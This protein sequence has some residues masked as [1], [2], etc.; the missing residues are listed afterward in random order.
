MCK[1]C[2]ECGQV[3]TFFLVAQDMFEAMEY[4]VKQHV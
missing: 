1:Q 2:R 3:F 4:G